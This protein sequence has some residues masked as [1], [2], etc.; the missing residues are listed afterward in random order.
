MT[1]QLI[2]AGAVRVDQ[3]DR[4]DVPD[5]LV[6][7]VEWLVTTYRRDATLRPCWAW[8]PD[9]VEELRGLW[10]HRLAADQA[11]TAPAGGEDDEDDPDD[12]LAALGLRA[13][14][15]LTAWHDTLERVGERVR[16]SMEVCRSD[17]HE[18]IRPAGW[19]TWLG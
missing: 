15:A 1:G 7:W 16:R 19:R 17:Q 12:P 2:P 10:L 14:A 6:G 18:A 5:E 8:H 13:T 3:L 11:A 9:V 4:P